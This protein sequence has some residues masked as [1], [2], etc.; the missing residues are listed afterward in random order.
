M[1]DALYPPAGTKDAT[2]YELTAADVAAL[3]NMTIANNIPLK[4]GDPSATITNG[5]FYGVQLPPILYADGTLGSPWT[6]GANQYGQ[7]IGESCAQLAA[8]M[9]P[10]SPYVGV[11]DWLRAENGNMPQKTKSGVQALCGLNGSNTTCATPVQI[12]AALWDNVGNAP[13]TS[14][15]GGKCFHIKYMGVFFVTGYDDTNNAVTGF[16]KTMSS[17]GG[18]VA[19]PGPILRMALVQ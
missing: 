11:G 17:A 12:T 19:K 8:D 18:F 1:L 14:G 4:V 15:C 9:A 2:T 13:G 5:N 7:A 16:F 6:G 10:S 3:S